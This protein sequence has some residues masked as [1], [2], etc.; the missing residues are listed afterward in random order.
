MFPRFLIYQL[1]SDPK[2]KVT[3]KYVNQAKL[4]MA[5]SVESLLLYETGT[6]IVAL[7]GTNFKFFELWTSLKKLHHHWQLLLP[8]PS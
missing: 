4:L 5:L 1:T 8:E 2:I 3:L 7:K 6:Q